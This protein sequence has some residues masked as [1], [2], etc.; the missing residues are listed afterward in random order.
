MAVTRL[1]ILFLSHRIPYPPNKGDKIRSWHLLNLCTRLGAV[2]LVTHA[3]DPRDLRHCEHLRESCR[4]VFVERL[5]AW[6]G[7]FRAGVALLGSTPLSVAWMTRTHVRRHVADLIA[8]N[9]YDLIVAFSTQVAS[10]VPKGC[11]V[12]VVLDAV[13]VDSEKWAAY[14]R[15]NGL[16]SLVARVEAKRMRRYEQCCGQRAGRVVLCT[17]R[18]AA[19]WREVVQSGTVMHIGNGVAV[20]DEVPGAAAREADLM[21]FSGAMDYE[22]NVLAAQLAARVI[23]P[24]VRALRPGAR[25]RIV[26][27][28]PTASVKALAA[29]PGVEVTGEVPSM[30]PHLEAASIALV[31]L[32]IARGIQNKVLEALA[33]GL[34]VVTTPVVAASLQDNGAG[35]MAVCAPEDM[36][37]V[38]SALLGD[39]AAR[40]RMAKLGRRH[41]QRNHCWSH[42]DA[43]FGQLFA[44][45]AQTKPV[46]GTQP[47]ASAAKAP[48]TCP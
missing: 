12:P 46:V 2:D 21:V 43:A 10:Y 18:E 27:R 8:N 24:E 48:S 34:P 29:L 6:T 4:S 17:P 13:D 9:D 16:R 19:L 45:I 22:P 3:D 11:T 44:S 40:E 20:P 35:G 38:A 36:A 47:Q 39:V 30:K 37:A 41:A 31:P 42:F 28:N 7:R 32:T 1:K 25:L 5:G 23:L 26:G 15:H 14:G 33:H